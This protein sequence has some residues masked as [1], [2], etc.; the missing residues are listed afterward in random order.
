MTHL[1]NTTLEQFLNVLDART[2]VTV[3]VDDT[4]APKKSNCM[5]Y[6]ILTDKEFIESY[7]FAQITSINICMGIT[8]ILVEKV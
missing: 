8:H 6:E 7:K 3:F 2:H 1:I 5:V 4:D